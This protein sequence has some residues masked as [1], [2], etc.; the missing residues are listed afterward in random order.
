MKPQVLFIGDLNTDL[1]E[2]A[3]FAQKYEC[4]QYRIS[5]VEDLVDAFSTKFNNIQAIYGAWLGFV[6]FGGFKDQ[7]LAAAPD[8]LKVVAICS[9][10][11][12]AY[13]GAAMA[14][15]GVVLTNVPSTGAAEPVADLVLYNALLS[16]RQFHVYPSH[17]TPSN[18]HTV[19][20]RAQ[21]AAGSF[22]SASGTA[23]RSDNF[24]YHYGHYINERPLLSP[25]GHSAL[26][27]GFGN[28][29]QTIGSRL[30]QIG[31]DVHYVKRTPLTPAQE[32][33]LGYKAHYHASVLDAK[34]HADLVVIA[35]PATPE[36]RHLINKEVIDAIARPFRLINIGRGVIV[37]EDALVAGLKAGKV[38][39]AGLDVYEN[40][41]VVHPELF[42]RQ[43]VILTPHI[44]A[45]TVE[46]FDYT[47]VQ[48]LKNIDD[49]L[50]GGAGL[51][52]VN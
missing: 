27:V 11:H 52:R 30:A 51:T 44:G 38:L 4:L 20:V 25:R 9:V 24:G 45:S 5:T 2:Y 17:L 29:G 6:P 10:G 19:K 50:L 18:N 1:P 26:V 43:D 31:M 7:I 39:F 47:A 33:A 42:G 8:S 34:D 16:F 32:A 49:V 41:P 3:A 37:D 40:E 21:L 12:D 15:R 35:C 28:I 46:N 36:T 22:D 14:A 23:G 13:D 48:A